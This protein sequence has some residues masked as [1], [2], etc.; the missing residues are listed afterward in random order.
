MWRLKCQRSGLY[1]RDFKQ[2]ELVLTHSEQMGLK[3]GPYDHA[4][5]MIDALG[6]IYPYFEWCAASVPVGEVQ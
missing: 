4:K 6:I 3:F 5:T 2:N 1:L